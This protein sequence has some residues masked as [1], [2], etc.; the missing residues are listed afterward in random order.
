LE[1]R[2][3]YG[4]IKPSKQITISFDMLVVKVRAGFTR[5]DEITKREEGECDDSKELAR[6]GA[7]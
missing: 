5:L 7:T 2:V 1:S 3:F 6:H 4:L